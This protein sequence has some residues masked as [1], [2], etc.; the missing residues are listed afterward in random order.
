MLTEYMLL[1][2]CKVH[3]LQTLKHEYMMD[4][5]SQGL[6]KVSDYVPG[7]LRYLEKHKFHV[8]VVYK[9]VIEMRTWKVQGPCL[10]KV[11]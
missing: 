3:C 4:H 11:G 8:F 1:F 10:V 5:Q 6:C 9:H 2:T 7:C